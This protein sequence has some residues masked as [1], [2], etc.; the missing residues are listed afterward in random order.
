MGLELGFG[1]GIG[2]ELRVGR[3]EAVARLQP[4]FDLRVVDLGW[5]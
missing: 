5:G 3:H 2:L 4:L 1:L